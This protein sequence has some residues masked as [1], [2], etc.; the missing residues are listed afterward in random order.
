V[1][2]SR[3]APRRPGVDEPSGWRTITAG[4]TPLAEKTIA[5]HWAR[6]GRSRRRSTEHLWPERPPAPELSGFGDSTLEG[7]QAAPI[8][9]ARFGFVN[10]T[11]KTVDDARGTSSAAGQGPLAALSPP[12]TMSQLEAGNT[13]HGVLNHR[14]ALTGPFGFAQL[15]SRA[16]RSGARTRCSPSAPRPER[17]NEPR[18][19]TDKL[20]LDVETTTPSRCRCRSRSGG[21]TH[22]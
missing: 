8:D 5:E 14:N 7:I 3:P 4:P 22:W 18:R 15:A 9:T 2:A 21:S 1:I 12:T 6:F 13:L 11:R 19:P 20:V 17:W 16:S 10:P